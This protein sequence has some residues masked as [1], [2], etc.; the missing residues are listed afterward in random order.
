MSLELG[1]DL[2]LSLLSSQSVSERCLDQHLV[3]L[4]A[5]LQGD[6]KSV[7]DRSLLR[8][9]VVSSQGRVFRARDALSQALQK[10]RG[11]SLA[12]V[13]VIVSDQAVED[14]HVSNHVLD[15][16]ITVGE[17]VHGLEL[18]VDNSDT[19]LVSSDYNVVDVLGGLAHAGEGLVDA[20]SGLNSGLRVELG[21]VR[22]L[23]ENVLHDVATVRPLELEGLLAEVNVVETPDRR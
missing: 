12:A 4:R 2:G 18:L 7:G 5:I 1:E 20:L 14:E 23:E 19:G 15:A 21:R 13:N 16:V 22:N 6:S 11:S 3:Q 17:V 8:V 9:V 10:R